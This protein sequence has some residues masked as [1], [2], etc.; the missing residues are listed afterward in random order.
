MIPDAHTPC[1]EPERISLA[2]ELIRRY[3]VREGWIP[4]GF[5]QWSVGP[6]DITVNGTAEERDALS[7]YHARIVH[8]EILAIMIINP[9]GGGVGGWRETEAD[10]IAA[11][12]A[13]L[14]AEPEA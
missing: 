3:A 11:M 2:F 5:R 9:Y 4:I 10:F 8:R 12:E 13:A 14:S 7:P 1:P 6:W